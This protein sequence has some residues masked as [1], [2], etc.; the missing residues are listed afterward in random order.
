M[1]FSA[2]VFTVEI[3]GVPRITF[4]AKWQADADHICRD[5]LHTHWDELSERG[6]RGLDLPP[7][8]KLRLAR[9]AERAAYEAEGTR[10]EFCGEVKVVNLIEIANYQQAEAVDENGS[11]QSGAENLG[12]ERSANDEQR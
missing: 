5:W 2:S 8:Y 1:M 6:P 4:Q 3:N 10:F 12:P 9:A 11:E 7:V